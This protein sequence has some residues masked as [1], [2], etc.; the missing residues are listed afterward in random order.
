MLVEH[1]GAESL[2]TVRMAQARTGHEEEG[3]DRDEVMATSPGYS[4]L[5]P[6][7][8]VGLRPDL[9]E[10]VLFSAGTG[11]RLEAGNQR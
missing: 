4:D 8:A 7:A 10:A 9:A 6:G 2:I 1:I 5:R 3:Q 11:Q